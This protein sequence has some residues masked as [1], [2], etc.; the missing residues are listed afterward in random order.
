MMSELVVFLLN[1]N[2]LS[3]EHHKF[4]KKVKTMTSFLSRAASAVRSALTQDAATLRVLEKNY[5]DVA[6]RSRLWGA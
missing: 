1:H 2:A 3:S 4:L 6:L 5:V